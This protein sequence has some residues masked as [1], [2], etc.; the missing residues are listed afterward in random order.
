MGATIG[1]TASL[2]QGYA[3]LAVHI[4]VI[5]AGESPRYQAACA[6]AIIILVVVLLLSLLVKLI[7]LRLNKFKGAN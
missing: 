1:D 6:I 2:T 7:S 4:Y 3:S 5:L